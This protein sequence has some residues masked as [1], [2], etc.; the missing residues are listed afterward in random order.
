[1]KTLETNL[2]QRKINKVDLLASFLEECEDQSFADFV[3]KIKLP[4]ETLAKYTSLL[5]NS[6][7]EFEHCLNCK[8][9]HACQ[10]KV[11]GFAYL[12]KI[13]QNNLEFQYKACRY[14][15]KYLKKTKHLD[16]V[17]LFDVPKEIKEASMKNIYMK[18]K[19]RFKVID[20]L[21]NF[22]E[23]Y[24]NNQHIKGLYLYGSFGCGKTYLIAAMFNELA[25]KNVK[26]AI[27]FWPEYLRDLK[28]SFN[29]D[30]NSK[31]NYIKRV[32][33]LL[34]DDIGAESVTAWGRDE[35]LCPIV[36]YRMQEKLPTFFTSNLDIERLE[37]HLSISKDEV[38]ILKSRRVIE[39]I[40]QLTEKEEI[41]SKNLRE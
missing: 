37:K 5:R 12:P 34:I 3:S 24:E 20:W 28:A 8:G 22:I 18:D 7:D 36:Q 25:K 39:R 13:N 31:V 32:P 40:K 38:D 33:L 4:Q 1:M 2:K 23:N 35:I 9:L 10:N 30:Y 26:S 11:T 27:I 15:E 17:Y 14:E 41:I 16:N 19:N 21:D 29:T 6:C